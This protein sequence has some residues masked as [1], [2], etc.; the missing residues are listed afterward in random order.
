MLA[1]EERGLAQGM[2]QIAAAYHHLSLG[3]RSAA[4][5]LYERARAKL[6]AWLP[7][8]A[9]IRLDALLQELERNI[10]TDQPRPGPMPPRIRT[11][12]VD[13]P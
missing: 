9:G 12:P 6:D 11:A 10:A 1:G 2:I 3:H 8:A 4:Q 7:D 13:I 5:Y